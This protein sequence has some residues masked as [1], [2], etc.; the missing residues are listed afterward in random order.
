MP[1]WA[2]VQKKK[3]N[4]KKKSEFLG[5]TDNTF[6]WVLK[7]LKNSGEAQNQKQFQMQL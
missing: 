4:L 6:F 5:S 2:T 3:K 1:K 7:N